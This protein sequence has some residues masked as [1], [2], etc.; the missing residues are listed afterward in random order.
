MSFETGISLR[1]LHSGI[2]RD[3]GCGPVRW[4]GGGSDDGVGMRRR[5]QSKEVERGLGQSGMA[6]AEGTQ[7]GL[8]A[9]A[10]TD[11]I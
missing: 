10:H 6:R 11:C 4:G 2:N 7:E 1:P 8:W 5:A 9:N 3:S